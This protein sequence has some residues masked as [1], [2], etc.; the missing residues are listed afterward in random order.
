MQQIADIELREKAYLWWKD[1]KQVTAKE[2]WVVWYMNDYDDVHLFL[3][4]HSR[5]SG[6]KQG[7][8]KE[9]EE[10]EQK[11][12]YWPCTQLA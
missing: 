8:M 6:S 3:Q 7:M 4:K 10:E 9:E 2:R 5:S 1:R 12:Q 11:K